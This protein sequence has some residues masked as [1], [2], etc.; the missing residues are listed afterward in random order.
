MINDKNNIENVDKELEKL[1][2]EAKPDYIPPALEI[3]FW[4]IGIFLIFMVVSCF[5]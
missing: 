2:M 1:K 4:L 5:Y 3:C